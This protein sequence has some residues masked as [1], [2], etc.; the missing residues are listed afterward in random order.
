[1]ILPK[2][3]PP[4]MRSVGG[5]ATR[6]RIVPAQVTEPEPDQAPD[7]KI[8]WGCSKMTV[9]D[10]DGNEVG[11]QPRKKVLAY[12]LAGIGAGSG[13]RIAPDFLCAEAAD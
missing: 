5:C 3:A 13:W 12:H 10:K 2:Q 7:R 4:V 8:K 9:L 11:N 1:M 6:A